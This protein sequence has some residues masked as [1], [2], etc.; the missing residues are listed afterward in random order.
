MAENVYATHTGN[1]AIASIDPVTIEVVRGWMESVTEEMQ[2]TV[3][4]T[5]HSPLICEAR[6]ATCA[7]FDRD[8][9]TAA[10]ASAMPVHLGVLAELGR[11]F[12][13]KYPSGEAQPGD[14][15]ITN[16]PYAGGTHMPDIAIS[17]PVFSKGELVGY[18]SSMAHHRD[19]G[20]LQPASVS[21]EARDIHAEG[22]RLPMIRIAHAGK[23]NADVMAVIEACS[24]TPISFRG[25]IGAQI[26]AC[27]TGV[28]RFAE[29]FER[30]PIDT[31][32]AAI[33]ALLDYSERMTRAEIAKIPDG[34]YY[35]ADKLDDN[36]LSADSD[37]IVIAL[38]MT[39]KGDEM[40]FDFAGTDDQVEAAINNVL[41]S[42]AAVV[43]YAVRTL[44][45]DQ[46]PNNDGCYRPITVRAPEGTI[47]NCTYPAPVA[48][49]GISLLR[50]EDVV[51]GVMAKALPD[52]MTAAHSG[53]YTMVGVAGI[54]PDTGESMIGHLSGPVVGGHGARPNK[55]GI[56]V[57][58]HG[59][60]NGSIV[61][62]EIG[63]A[64]YPIRFKTL[65]LWQDSGGAGRWR[66]GLGY[67]AEVEWLRGESMITFRRERTRFKPWGVQGGGPAPLCRTELVRRDGKT[68]ALPAKV[69]VPL[70]A[71]EKLKYWTTGSGGHGPALRRD[72]E[73]VLQDVLDGRVSETSA[74]EEYGVVIRDEAID[75]AATKKL[76]EQMGVDRR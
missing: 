49:R 13:E 16:D 31:V 8:G 44:T 1:E 70:H 41:A 22:M 58:S 3:V 60:T 72:P 30:W 40:I 12:A 19:I 42:T 38:T 74:R 26:A 2:A 64:R 52:R 54:D 11:R 35:F 15:Y 34:D 28:R 36:A 71:G 21:V 18:V 73:R 33:T 29:L 37:P 53:Q 14:L 66:G 23:M 45:G 43:Y 67:F 51:N 65:E 48:S 25:D 4:K 56:D 69:V 32:Y 20:G 46:V 7:L 55:D 75:I 24:R 50:I 39:V 62:M 57:S 27:N 59:C 6:D 76:R 47:V 5:A 68:Q 17:A 9:R 10:Q 61:P 63:E